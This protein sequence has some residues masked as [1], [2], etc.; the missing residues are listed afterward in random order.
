MAADGVGTILLVEDEAN[1]RNSL[2]FI[3]GLEGYTVLGA[4]SGEEGVALA[5]RHGPD[6]VLLDLGLPGIDGFE[7]ARQLAPERARGT[8]IVVLTG[9][10]DED[11][12][13][14]AIDGF[15]DDYVVKP[16][17][18]R[19]LLARLRMLL[20]RSPSAPAAP[21]AEPNRA[22]TVGPL[23]MDLD[24]HE[25]WIG[26]APLAL[27]RTEFALLALLAGQRHRVHGRLDLIAAVHGSPCAVSERS[28]DFQIHGLR[29]KLE[30]CGVHIHTL[31]GVGFKLVVDGAP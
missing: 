30:P 27:T 16:V 24:A 22:L 31:R 7:V 26:E 29:R 28:I 12:M 4:A 21:A 8:R 18:P 11:E 17:R 23:R 6:V 10:D 13:V 19:V 25:V 20:G 2:G 14:R 9:H 15:A 5:R 1:L 3:L